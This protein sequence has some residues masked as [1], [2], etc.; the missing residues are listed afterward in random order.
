MF[1]RYVLAGA[2]APDVNVHIKQQ[3]NDAADAARLHGEIRA[4][5]EEEA[6]RAVINRVGA[7]N[8]VLIA[9]IDTHNNFMT[10][11]KEARVLFT[12]NGNLYD[13]RVSISAHDI[14]EWPL[15]VLAGYVTARIVDALKRRR[16]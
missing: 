2:S 14:S 10:D 1:D 3:P 11:H 7:N 16:P 4:K 9:R 6:A 8:D 12:V 15:E 5:A 13:E